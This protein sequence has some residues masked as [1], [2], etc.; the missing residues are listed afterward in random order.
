MAQE[1]LI[2]TNSTTGNDLVLKK[3]HPFNLLVWPRQD[4]NH[5]AVSRF[6]R[7]ATSLVKERRRKAN[8]LAL[9]KWLRSND[10]RAM[11]EARR[12][13]VAHAEFD[14][15]D[16]AL[17]QFRLFRPAHPEVEL[18]LMVTQVEQNFSLSLYPRQLS[19]NRPRA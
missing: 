14:A 16:R 1:T 6:E 11:A 19:A 12:I 5:A 18:T 2:S 13:I 4:T 17:R 10:D 3:V 15:K 8:W 9:L 7:N